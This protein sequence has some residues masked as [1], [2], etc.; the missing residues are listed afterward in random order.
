ME[1][2]HIETTLHYGSTYINTSACR[3][4]EQ[5]AVITL[6]ERIDMLEELLEEGNE[7]RTMLMRKYKRREGIM[8][9]VLLLM[10]FYCIIGL[11]IC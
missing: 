8:A 10:T 6:R 3:G 1:A 7:E 5:G 11:I 2:D 4:V 9:T